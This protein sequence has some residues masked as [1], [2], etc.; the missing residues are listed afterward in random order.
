MLLIRLLSGQSRARY[1]RIAV[2]ALLIGMV[3]A[4]SAESPK[5]P[6]AAP[7]I[8]YQTPQQGFTEAMRHSIGAPAQADLGDQA[9]VRLDADLIVVPHDQASRLLKIWDVP[10]PPD[11][12]ALLLG[13]KG[14]DAPGIIRFIP[15]GFIDAAEALR[16]TQEDLLSSL[17]DTIEARN[18]VRITEQLPELEVRGWIRPPHTDA[19][20]S[21][22]T[23][24]ALILPKTAEPDTDGEITYYA[25]GFG[26]HGYIQVSMAA[27][28]QD[29]PD[30]WQMF[31]TF[32]SGLAFRPGDAYG[33]VQPADRRSPAGVSG[34]LGIDQLHKDRN[35]E[36][37][38]VSD[39]VIPYAGGVVAVV[40]AV[41]LLIY[42][43]HHVRR[44]SS[45]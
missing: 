9:T 3:R 28:L 32:L 44:E 10:V 1:L 12:V 31:G 27:S 18:P 4:A 15:A 25:V 39:L 19:K 7:A 17:S 24:A 37:F 8:V 38:W 29:A 26:R 41:S 6:P 5:A 2:L 30:I 43:R 14:M 40:G 23:W 34:V 36:S 20:T 16:W 42:I 35:A 11:L 33:D 21:Q 22:M 45:R 13:P